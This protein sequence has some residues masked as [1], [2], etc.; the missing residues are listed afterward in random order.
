MAISGICAL[1]ESRTVRRR[2]ALA[3]ACALVPLA[4]LAQPSTET[5]E[6][7]WD[8]LN[9]YCIEC[10]NFTDWAGEI[11]FDVM[12]P[13]GIADDAE[14]WEHA[15]RKIRG[16]LMPPPGEA[17]PE[18]A[19]LTG[20]AQSLEDYLDAVAE[21][22][23]PE[24]GHVSLQ[25]L[26]R[27]EYANAVH[28][29]LAIEIEPEIYLP[30]DNSA[31]GFDNI[32]NVLKVS[33]TFLD[34][35]LAA[36]REISIRAVGD[37]APDAGRAIYIASG[38]DQTS[39]IDGLPLGTR[40]GLVAEH[41]FPADG[42]Y[43]FNISGLLSA[44]YVYGVYDAHT[45]ILTVDGKRVF[46]AALGGDSDFRAVD[47][48]QE[49]V[50][51]QVRE[52]F[53]NIEVPV[54]AGRHKVGV[55]FIQRAMAESD[56]VLQPL[57]PIRLD[58]GGN[59]GGMDEISRIETLEVLGPFDPTGIS[60][61]PS[62][63]KIFSCYPDQPSEEW[64]CAQQIFAEIGRKAFRR[65][66]TEEDMATIEAFYRSG[67]SEGGFETG[68]QKGIMS[69]LASPKFL[70]RG[71]PPREDL[72][73]G[74][75]Y[76]V[77]QLELASRLSFFLWS[78]LPDDALLDA[79]LAGELREPSV[80]RAQIKRMLDDPR[81][82]QTLTTDFAF[83]WLEITALDHLEDRDPDRYPNFDDG[84]TKAFREEMELYLGSIFAADRN[85]L[86]LLTADHTFVNERL[87][88]FYGV[89]GV[90]GDKFRRVTLEDDRRWGLLGKG[91]VLT[92]SSYPHRTSPV[93]RG[94]WILANIVGAPPEAPPPGVDT[95]LDEDPSTTEATTVRGRLE[96]HR[97]DPSCNNCH[98]IIDPLG[99]ALEN[100][101]AI[102][103]WRDIDRYTATL[104][105]ASGDL[106]GIGAISGP[107]DLRAALT[108][109]PDQFART[110]TEKLLS[111]ALGRT[112]TASDMP[113]VRAILR[114]AAKDDYRVS[115]I[116]TGI[117][118]SAPFQMER[119]PEAAEPAPSQ[120]ASLAP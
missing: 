50:A 104:I 14:I 6:K 26:N 21:T 8:V 105:D 36:A 119:A 4:G 30:P 98:G 95:D 13:D 12:T 93:L 62:R 52:R 75:L 101:N 66:V 1:P 55:T 3:A 102:G 117:V 81:A 67:V 56:D 71:A 78:S 110:F 5:V 59:S 19:V 51:N 83:Q 20:L 114:D 106:A 84:L 27:K 60:D 86:D 82:T 91:A 10:H 70:Y 116:V 109:D 43:V 64:S 68:V 79:A 89:P 33:P 41:D 94:Q 103:E 31:G 85:V 45:L 23:P 46:E 65:P 39:H 58:A 40:G 112:L 38:E 113:V 48:G 15:I 120:E 74:T 100:F 73:P 92:V 35:Y 34:Q 2:A 76:E 96:Q 25:R 9:Q 18:A 90:N 24:P 115:A 57:N 97:A 37:P 29:L 49:A 87:A 54:Q 99:L 77:S 53:R 22:S 28:D 44:R 72:E 17:R 107:A 88:D 80:L 11:A 63:R 47:Q 42:N 61:T 7:N 108:A 32:A 111:Y 118:M 69:I 16:G